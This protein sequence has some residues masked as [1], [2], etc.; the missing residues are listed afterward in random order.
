VTDVG[1]KTNSVCG[2]VTTTLDGNVSINENETDDGTLENST[3]AE[4]EFKTMKFVDDN[5]QTDETGTTTGDDHVFGTTTV[6]GTV[7]NDDNGIDTKADVGIVAI[8]LNGTEFGT[9][10]HEITTLVEPT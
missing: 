8:T 9:F 4:T 7:T 10:V 2:T 1:T 6:D 5:D 3:T